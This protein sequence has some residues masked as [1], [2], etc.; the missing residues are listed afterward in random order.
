[1]AG[2]VVTPKVGDRVEIN[3]GY[4]TSGLAGRLGTVVEAPPEHAL[5]KDMIEVV[6]DQGL[7]LELHLTEFRLLD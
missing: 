2:E 5:E 3:C 4:H 7:K 6:L 1:M